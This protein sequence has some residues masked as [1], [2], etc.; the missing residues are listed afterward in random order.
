MVY[1]QGART[2]IKTNPILGTDA[3]VAYNAPIT[4]QCEY[5]NSTCNG[6][7]HLGC[8]EVE[9]CGPPVEGQQNHCYVL[10]SIQEDGTVNVSLKVKFNIEK[11]GKI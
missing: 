7:G 5:Y 11:L 8:M 3:A 6:A 2:I 4:T 10:W 9:Q 1:K